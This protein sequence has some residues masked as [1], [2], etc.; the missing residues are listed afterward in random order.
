MEHLAEQLQGKRM[1]AA[2][3]LR[4]EIVEKAQWSSQWQESVTDIDQQVD[5][6][7]PE[8]ELVDLYP[9]DLPPSLKLVS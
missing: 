5:K 3:S 7:R 8:L 6:K 4:L 1:H 2:C 9:Q